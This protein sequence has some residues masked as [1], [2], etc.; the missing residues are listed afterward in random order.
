MTK[1]LVKTVM[2]LLFWKPAKWR[3]GFKMKLESRLYSGAVRRRAKN[4]EK[5]IEIRRDITY[6]D[7]V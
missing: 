6:T 5:T 4:E 1:L 2:A 3:R 7:M